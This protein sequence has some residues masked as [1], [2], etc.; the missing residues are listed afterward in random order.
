MLRGSLFI[1]S[2]TGFNLIEDSESPEYIHWVTVDYAMYPDITPTLSGEILMQYLSDHMTHYQC[3]IHTEAHHHENPWCQ[4]IAVYADEDLHPK[5]VVAIAIEQCHWYAKDIREGRLMVDKE[6]IF[7]GEVPTPETQPFDE[8]ID[9][10]DRPV[11]QY[12]WTE[13]LDDLSDGLLYS[14]SSS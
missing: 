14:N 12:L 2:E 13:A 11:D 5:E 6:K 7:R 4:S 8:S 3:R 9:L 1:D 10:E